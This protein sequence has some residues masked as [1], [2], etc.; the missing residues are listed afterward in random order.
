MPRLL[1]AVA[2]CTLRIIMEE[3]TMPHHDRKVH[4]ILGAG[5]NVKTITGL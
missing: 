2:I 5:S 3:L 4:A 1:T